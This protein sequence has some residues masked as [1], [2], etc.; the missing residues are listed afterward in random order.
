[1]GVL[2]LARGAL[3][4]AA[5]A[6]GRRWRP[7][8]FSP[9]TMGRELRKREVKNRKT[10]WRARG[11]TALEAVRAGGCAG[12]DLPRG[13]VPRRVSG[14]RSGR[15]RARRARDRAGS[16]ARGTCPKSAAGPRERAET[17][18][19]VS[20]FR[21]R[22]RRKRPG[23][24]KLLCRRGE[25]SWARVFTDPGAR[26]VAGPDASRRAATAAGGAPR[27]RHWV[28]PEGKGGAT[29][30]RRPAMGSAGGG[31]GWRGPAGSAFGQPGAF[32]GQPDP[33]L[34]L[35]H[36]DGSEGLSGT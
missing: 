2:A 5:A 16:A 9:H 3:G 29:V 34:P 11:M 12:P 10:Y 7:Q 24:R 6:L 17:H 1:M 14:A 36:L 28:A 18:D 15:G 20:R 22:L 32:V 4:P 21:R 25:P 8:L 33:A 31:R 35:L 30:D 19:P 23:V 13:R 27:S 26:L